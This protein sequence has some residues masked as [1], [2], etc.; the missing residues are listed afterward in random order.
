M[1]FIFSSI[2]LEAAA[3]GGGGTMQMILLVGMLAVFYIF[4][5]LPQSKKQKKQRKFVEEL[6]K[7]QQV[8]TAGGMHGKIV[9]VEDHTVT[10]EVDRGIKIRFEKGSVSLEN[11][12]ALTEGKEKPALDKKEETAS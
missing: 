10:L 5:I 7:G 2:L 1:T 4:M 3:G 9:S 11:T 8:V 6:K 12:T